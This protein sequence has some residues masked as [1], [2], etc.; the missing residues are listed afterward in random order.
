MFLSRSSFELDISKWHVSV[1]NKKERKNERNWND[2]TLCFSIKQNT[3]FLRS[4]FESNIV[5]WERRSRNIRTSTQH[6]DCLTVF[7]SRLSLRRNYNLTIRESFPEK[8]SSYIQSK[9][10]QIEENHIYYLHVA[11]ETFSTKFQKEI[12]CQAMK[13]CEWNRRRRIFEVRRWEM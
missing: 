3:R 12:S 4:S 8:N 9:V 7:V 13:T 5:K 11:L 1:T 2:T 6:K 10:S